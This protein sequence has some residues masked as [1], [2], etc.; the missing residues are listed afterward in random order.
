MLELKQI[1]LRC[2]WKIRGI[3]KYYK[4]DITNFWQP[5]QDAWS[6]TQIIVL[7]YFVNYYIVEPNFL[8]YYATKLQIPA[9]WEYS[10]LFY[11][12]QW[13]FIFQRIFQFKRVSSHKIRDRI[14]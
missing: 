12:S 14:K 6:F 5:G 13:H 8:L 3:G 2:N 10:R 11:P 7:V 1:D 4:N 9:L